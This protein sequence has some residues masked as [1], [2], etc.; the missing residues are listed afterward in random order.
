MKIRRK[1]FR[2]TLALMLIPAIASLGA[3]SGSNPLPESDF[4]GIWKSSRAPDTPISLYDNGEWE[5]KNVNGEVTQYGVW[6]IVG[7]NK[8]MWSY[9]KESGRVVHEVNAVLSVTG[10][11]F[12]VKELDGST[13]IFTRL[14]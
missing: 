1:M 4:V 7:Q 14:G 6:Q 3:C 10:S 2:W 8:I 12:K 11:E 13:T 9:R 5:V